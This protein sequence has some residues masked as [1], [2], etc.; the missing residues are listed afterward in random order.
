[1]LA[2]HVLAPPA[3]VRAATGAVRAPVVSGPTA[4]A[5]GVARMFVVPVATRDVVAT[6]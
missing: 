6:G 1:M 5:I 4:D 3:P 2:V